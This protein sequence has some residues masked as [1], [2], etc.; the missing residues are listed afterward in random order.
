MSSLKFNVRG[1]YGSLRVQTKTVA[2]LAMLLCASVVAKAQVVAE[3]FGGHQNAAHEVWWSKP[4]AEQSRFS[5]FSYTRFRTHY[6]TSAKN[7]FLSYSTANY[8]IGKGFGV[9]AGGFITNFGFSPVVAANYFF[10]NDTWLVN[11][12]PSVEVKQ[13]ANAEL[14]LF[15]QF[16][17]KLTNKLR[18]FSQLIV[19]FN[20]NF[21]YH[22][23]SEE[24]LRIGLDYKTFQFG[25]GSDFGQIRNTETNATLHTLNYGLFLRKEF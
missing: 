2:L 13:N 5:F 25:L 16:R 4:F 3:V 1:G 19:N 10:Q 24:N 20:A 11:V 23:F 12:F 17:P 22:N 6:Q 14:F 18:L 21:Q 15:L 8:E 9:A 7:E